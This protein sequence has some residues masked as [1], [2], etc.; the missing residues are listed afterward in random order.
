MWKT[1]M[2]RHAGTTTAWPAWQP[3]LCTATQATTALS[4][5]LCQHKQQQQQERRKQQKQQRMLRDFGQLH[6]LRQLQQ[7][8]QQEPQSHASSCP[9]TQP[10]LHHSH[11]NRDLPML[12]LL[13]LL[14][15]LLLHTW[16]RLRRVWMA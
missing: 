6:V 14:L 9:Y 12:L 1:R 2:R 13:L 8:L 3:R 15:Q 4:Q 10:L 7:Q 16:R 5:P 11:D